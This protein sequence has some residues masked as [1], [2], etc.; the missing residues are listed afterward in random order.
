MLGHM[1]DKTT[2]PPGPDDAAALEH[3]KRLARVDAEL[4]RTRAG[5]FRDLAE[6][7]DALVGSAASKQ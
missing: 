5:V 6:G 7:Y 2:L 3:A 4:A 1:H